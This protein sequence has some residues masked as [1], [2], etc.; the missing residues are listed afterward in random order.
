VQALDVATEIEALWRVCGDLFV[1]AIP[2]RTSGS[3]DR[4]RSELIFC[5]L[6]GYGVPFELAASASARA[7]QLNVFDPG[8]DEPSLENA[9]REELAAPQ[10]EPRRLNGSLRRYRFPHRKAQLIV[11]ARRWLAER[12]PIYEF[13]RGT[14]CEAQRR[15]VLCECPGVGLKTASWILRNLGLASRLAVVDVHVVRALQR[16]GRID[17]VRLPRDYGLAETAFLKWSDD[18][19]APAAAFDLFLWEWQ[20]GLFTSVDV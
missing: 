14:T 18:L 10:F 17:S 20:R 19:A 3:E 12:E 8:W 11:S 2:P 9:I 1:E 7:E 5:L 16:V 6:G 4:L 15:F 13:L